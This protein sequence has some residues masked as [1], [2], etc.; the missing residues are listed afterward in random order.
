MPSKEWEAVPHAEGEISRYHG[1]FPFAQ[2]TNVL[3]N[4]VIS[5][6]SAVV[7]CYKKSAPAQLFAG[8]EQG[9]GGCDE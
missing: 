8:A 7:A 1:R 9:A 2:P 5:H 4:K 6:K 3:I